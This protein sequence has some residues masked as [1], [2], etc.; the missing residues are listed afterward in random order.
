[1]AAPRVRVSTPGLMAALSIGCLCRSSFVPVCVVSRVEI[2]KEGSS[3]LKEFLQYSTS[4]TIGGWYVV[5]VVD[6]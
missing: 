4:S 2:F 3:L 5:V 1:M 6:D